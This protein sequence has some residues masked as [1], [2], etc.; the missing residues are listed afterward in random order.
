MLDFPRQ[1]HARRTERIVEAVVGTSGASYVT[2]F[3]EGVGTSGT[4]SLT[5]TMTVPIGNGTSSTLM[6]RSRYC[7]ALSYLPNFPSPI[8]NSMISRATS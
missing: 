1:S 7:L 6:L 5:S 3:M 4:I 8:W 2:G